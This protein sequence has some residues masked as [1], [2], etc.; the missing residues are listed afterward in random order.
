MKWCSE[1]LLCVLLEDRQKRK[2]A[3]RCFTPYRHSVQ[4]CLHLD[5]QIGRVGGWKGTRLLSDLLL[6]E[7]WSCCCH[8]LELLL[9]L[10]VFSLVP[11][12]RSP[13]PST[14]P[15]QIT[16]H[17]NSTKN[18]AFSPVFPHPY[19]GSLPRGLNDAVKGVPLMNW[20]WKVCRKRT[21]ITCTV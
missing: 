2:D 15:Q 9:F 8:L 13:L 16:C 20:G 21:F 10:E 7:R 19:P 14:T 11:P 17:F 5:I 3:Y 18:S 1:L 4:E 6:L 12:F